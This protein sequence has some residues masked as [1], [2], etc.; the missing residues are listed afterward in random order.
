MRKNYRQLK[1]NDRRRLRRIA[2]AHGKRNGKLYHKKSNKQVL[3]IAKAR[4]VL[5]KVHKKKVEGKLHQNNKETMESF[6]KSYRFNAGHAKEL[7]AT[8]DHR[9]EYCRYTKPLRRDIGPNYPPTKIQ[10]YKACEK[11]RIQFRSEF[12]VDK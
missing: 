11:L 7:L 5:K 8:I 2:T 12:K 6:S 9:C 4:S 1:K 3:T 10:Q